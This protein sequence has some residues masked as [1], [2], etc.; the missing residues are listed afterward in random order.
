M[1]VTKLP[2]YRLNFRATN[3]AFLYTNSRFK[4]SL[5]FL[6]YGLSFI[7][8]QDLC[9]HYVRTSKQFNNECQSGVSPMW[10]RFCLVSFETCIKIG[11]GIGD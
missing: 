6:G 8:L 11:I 3:D 7:L 2:G 10:N 4:S 9:V 1:R 5:D